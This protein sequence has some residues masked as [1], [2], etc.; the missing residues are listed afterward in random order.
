MEQLPNPPVTAYVIA[1]RAF[2][3]RMRAVRWGDEGHSPR[4]R[5]R[6]RKLY[7]YCV[8]YDNSTA[9]VAVDCIASSSHN[10]S[11]RNAIIV[12]W[13]ILRDACKSF[14]NILLNQA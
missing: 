3:Q 10:N 13:I 12:Q 5:S 1:T 9:V 2:E 7:K 11:V 4:T 8:S 14:L 6:S